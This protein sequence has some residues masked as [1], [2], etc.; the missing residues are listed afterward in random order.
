M[1]PQCDSFEVAVIDLVNRAFPDARK[2]IR[3]RFGH[4]MRG[5]RMTVE[6]VVCIEGNDQSAPPRWGLREVK[7]EK[8]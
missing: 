4:G 2:S 8:N 3:A 6:A 7:T 5:N 1:K